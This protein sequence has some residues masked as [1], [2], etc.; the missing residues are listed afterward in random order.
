MYDVGSGKS[1]SLNQLIIEA[2][3]EHG[4]EIS[5]QGLDKKFNYGVID[6]VKRL[7]GK[8]LSVRI[9]HQIESEWLKKFSRVILKDG[10]RFDIPD[11]F[12]DIL[13]GSGGSASKAGACIQFEYDLKTGS[14]IQLDIT[15][16][17]R[18]DKREATEVLND[19]S[20]G[21]LVIRDLGYHLYKSFLNIITKKAFFISR[22]H[23]KTNVFILKNGFYQRLDFK[24]VYNKMKGQRNGWKYMSVFIGDEK[25]PVN[26]TVEVVP[27][28]VRERRIRNA[29]KN[30]N[31]KGRKTS[32]KF[33]FFAGLSIFITNIPKDD[34]P[35][36]ILSTLYRIRWQIELIFKIWKS[37]FCINHKTLMKF[38]RWLCLLYVRLLLMIMN[39]NIIMNRRNYL[40]RYSGDLLSLNK[41]FKT[42]F[43]NNYRLRRALKQG[44]G[45]VRK[46]LRWASKILDNNHWLEEKKKSKGLKE[47]LSIKICKSIKY[48]YI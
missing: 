26:M 22:L 23:P 17:N 31:K 36:R 6:F 5:K 48:A 16:G 25:I 18:P 38:K 43:E 27:E 40:H 33:K 44:A 35:P 30:N 29:E 28:A 14:I 15:P 37:I 9:N 21:D 7:I 19:V 24:E 12:K 13:P 20:E 32:E 47:I 11:K 2:K 4:I 34:L 10:T 8:Q 45:E 41:C 1:K 39:W 42:L 3:S 46:L